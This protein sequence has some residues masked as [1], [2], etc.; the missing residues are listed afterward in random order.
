MIVRQSSSSSGNGTESRPTPPARPKR[1]SKQISGFINSARL[2]ARKQPMKPPT[3]SEDFPSPGEI[4]TT[5]P[6]AT[7]ERE[8]ISGGRIENDG[9]RDLSGTDLVV[10]IDLQQSL[11]DRLNSENRELTMKT[12]ELQNMASV[13]SQENDRL[14]SSLTLQT[15]SSNMDYM[16]R[17]MNV[18]DGGAGKDGE[19]R[20]TLRT[21]KD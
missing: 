17:H 14:R 12:T 15:A 16:L 5:D 4:V 19:C 9:F 1:L 21:R 8:S 11:L 3:T 18:D 2:H 20:R 6:H 10:L 7:V 13:L